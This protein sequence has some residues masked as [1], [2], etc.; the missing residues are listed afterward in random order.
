MTDKQFKM[1]ERY[2]NKLKET[3]TSRVSIYLAK[4]TAEKYDM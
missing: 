3:N 1:S 4:W 2:A